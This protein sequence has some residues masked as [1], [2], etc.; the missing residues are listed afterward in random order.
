MGEHTD[1]Y[2]KTCMFGCVVYI[3]NNFD[4]GEL[5]YPQL[6]S[7][8]VP[9]PGTLIAHAGDEPHLVTTV[10]RGTRYMLTCFIYGSDSHKPKINYEAITKQ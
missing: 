9:T 8:F 5:I 4:G 1:N 2:N 10:S 6:E 3:N 7:K